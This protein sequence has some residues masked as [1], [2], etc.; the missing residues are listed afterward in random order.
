M[1]I[2]TFYIFKKEWF[3]RKLFADIRLMIFKRIMLFS[4][5]LVVKLHGDLW[6]GG[7]FKPLGFVLGS[8]E[9]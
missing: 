5:F 2:F 7:L 1:K 8:K 4:K 6:K 9:G 3:P